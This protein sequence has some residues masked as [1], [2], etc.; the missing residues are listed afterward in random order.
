MVMQDLFPSDARNKVR[1]EELAQDSEETHAGS[2]EC[3][4]VL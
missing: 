3:Y 2:G 4:N 1:C